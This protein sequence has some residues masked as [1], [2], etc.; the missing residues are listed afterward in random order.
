MIFVALGA[1]KFPFPRLLKE[2]EN[3]IKTFDI[4][5][6]VIVQRGNTG[7]TSP[8][9]ESFETVPVAEFY[10][11]V[12]KAEVVI[13]QAG[14]GSLFDTMKIGKKI[15]AAA[16]LKKYG[17]VID[18]HQLELAKKLSDEGY[19]LDGSYSL[20]AAW[21]KLANFS[22]RPFDFSNQ[23]VTSLKSYINTI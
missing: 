23:I 2:L 16:R 19:I 20:G 7:Y 21:E 10:E 1:V 4:S 22:P 11:Y 3:L 14:S 8:L 17:E 5:D 6:E 18:D 12:K 13:M 15:I 9:F